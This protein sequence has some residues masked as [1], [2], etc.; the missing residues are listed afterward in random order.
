MGSEP[1]SFSFD[2]PFVVESEFSLTMATRPDGTC[3]VRLRGEVD[4]GNIDEFSE[5][6]QGLLG[7]R[8]DRLVLDLSS[9]GFLSVEAVRLL[10]AA[11]EVLR[12]RNRTR[13]VAQSPSRIQRRIL[14]L[15]DAHRVIEMEPCND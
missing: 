12:R 15:I 13:V 7:C 6:L 14:G 1:L 9:L 3:L 2:D 11:A 8:T 4:L 10:V 5:S